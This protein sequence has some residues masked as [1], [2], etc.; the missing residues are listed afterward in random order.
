[1][2]LS[3]CDSYVAHSMYLSQRTNSYMF[4]FKPP[5]LTS[6]GC[7]VADHCLWFYWFEWYVCRW[8]ELA[9]PGSNKP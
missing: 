4:H 1:L 8:C 5:G 7:D 3:E 9:F 2:L 6:V